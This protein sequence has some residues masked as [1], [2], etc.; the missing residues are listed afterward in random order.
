MLSFRAGRKG[1]AKGVRKADSSRTVPDVV[2]DEIPTAG[3]SSSGPSAGPSRRGA[4]AGP[5][6]SS[7]G[8]PPSVSTRPRTKTAFAP[9]F[10]RKSP[11]A[12]PP[13]APELS[14]WR[15]DPDDEDPDFVVDEIEEISSPPPPRRMG[16]RGMPSASQSM[17]DGY[18]SEIEEDP[19]PY[20]VTIIRQEDLHGEEEAEEADMGGG[21]V[22]VPM[23]CRAE[24]L[25][26]RDQVRAEAAARAF[27][28]EAFRNQDHRRG[29]ADG[30]CA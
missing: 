7:G 21:D 29:R 28:A 12:E 11:L 16:T 27:W 6:S 19:A 18:T 25:R 17:A 1:G 13:A 8:L 30:T 5:S 14:L 15:D 26:L 9:A 2:M 23:R 24:L 20:R 10:T 22:D 3:P 4:S